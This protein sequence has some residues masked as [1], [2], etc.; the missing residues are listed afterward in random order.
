ML[1]I[2]LALICYM[3]CARLYLKPNTPLKKTEYAD[4]WFT[5]ARII[6]YAVKL[7]PVLFHIYKLHTKEYVNT[8]HDDFDVCILKYSWL[9]QK[10]YRMYDDALEVALRKVHQRNQA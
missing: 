8:S 2:I 3:I 10:H 9:T 1:L 4:V 7:I 6:F 5:P